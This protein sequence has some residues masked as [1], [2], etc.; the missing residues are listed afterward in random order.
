M[1]TLGQTDLQVAAAIPPAKGQYTGWDW[2]TFYNAILHVMQNPA[3]QGAYYKAYGLIDRLPER[4]KFTPQVLTAGW[5]RFS[6]L[7]PGWEAHQYRAAYDTMYMMAKQAGRLTEGDESQWW[8]V[9]QEWQ[10]MEVPKFGYI[11]FAQGRAVGY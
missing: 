10:A 3:S 1:I 9:E 2:Q 5:A 6:S 11:P 7:Y 8:T 4:M